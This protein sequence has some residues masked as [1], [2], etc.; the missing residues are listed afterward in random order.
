MTLLELQIRTQQ[1]LKEK[2]DHAKKMNADPSCVNGYNE[3][4]LLNE[5]IEHLI[6]ESA[7]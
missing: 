5:L 7:K 1:L 4:F 3:L 2:T 6:K